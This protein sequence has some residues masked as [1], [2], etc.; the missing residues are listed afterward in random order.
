MLVE[1]EERR[2]VLAGPAHDSLEQLAQTVLHPVHFQDDPQ[3]LAGLA[4]AD[5]QVDPL[6][7][8]LS[9]GQHV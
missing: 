7:I 5:H 1:D 4:L 8:V 2:Q 6:H 3:S 9:H